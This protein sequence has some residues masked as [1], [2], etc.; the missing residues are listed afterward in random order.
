VQHTMKCLR[1][2]STQLFSLPT[3]VHHVID[4]IAGEFTMCITIQVDNMSIIYRVLSNRSGRHA[5]GLANLQVT[6]L[7]HLNDSFVAGV[8]VFH[9]CV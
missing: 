7:S 8:D 4:P 1:A 3:G 9:V 2:S 6:H 5:V